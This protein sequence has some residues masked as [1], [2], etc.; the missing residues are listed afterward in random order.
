M[1]HDEH[2]MMVEFSE[3]GVFNINVKKFEEVKEDFKACRDRVT[4]LETFLSSLV[5]GFQSEYSC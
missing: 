5:N 3:I 1:E 4:R 2:E